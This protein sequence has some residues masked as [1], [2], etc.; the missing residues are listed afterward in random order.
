MSA[1]LAILVPVLERPHRVAPLLASI[2]AA[3][4]GAEVWF[5]ADP[6]DDAQISAV[7]R[8]GTEA[9]GVLHQL[10]FA[11][12]SYAEK[13]NRAVALTKTPFVFLGADDLNFRSGWFEAAKAALERGVEVVGVNDLLRRRRGRRGH[14]THFL[15][16]RNYAE[17]PTIDG[18]R[19]PL[20]ENYTHN[21][22]DDELIATATAR[23][24]YAYAQDAH[25]EHLHWMNRK[26]AVDETYQRGKDA[27]EADRAL[28]GERELLW[29]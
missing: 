29:A 16:T 1:D 19:G 4:P 15:M 22:V 28:F 13:I 26:A 11:G 5:L 12:G 27:F 14:A 20:C 21:F 24:V 18:G 17:R 2:E 23:G 3:T 8:H 10:D 9:V 6:Q 25:V 7:M